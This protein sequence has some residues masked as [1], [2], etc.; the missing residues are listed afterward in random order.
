M[1]PNTQRRGLTVLHG[2]P[3]PN[4]SL[5]EPAPPSTLTSIKTPC[6]YIGPAGQRC[7]RPA[8]TDGFCAKHRLGSPAVDEPES[9]FAKRAIAIITVL[10]A[11][12]PVLADLIRE[13]IRLLR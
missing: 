4:L 6:L 2:T 7:N 5:P 13:L 8:L 11:L 3:T 9:T 12:W 1:E 10:V